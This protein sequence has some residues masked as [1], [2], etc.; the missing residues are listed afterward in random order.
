MNNSLS[1]ITKIRNAQILSGIFFLLILNSLKAEED[2]A[3]FNNRMYEGSII[4]SVIYAEKCLMDHEFE[5]ANS[6]FWTCRSQ[7][8][9]LTFP[10][11]NLKLR[12]ELGILLSEL[13][14][15]PEQFIFGESY[16]DRLNSLLSQFTESTK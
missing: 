3:H 11:K 14:A 15:R 4:T 5:N 16:G 8:E 1:F 10:N 12:I 13:L 2:F 7:F 9:L 6:Y